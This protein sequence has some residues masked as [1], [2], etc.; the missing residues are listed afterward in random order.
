M[1]KEILVILLLLLSGCGRHRV[2]ACELKD[3]EKEIHINI[4]ATNDDI[5][6]IHIEEALYIPYK[7]LLSKESLIEIE[8][9]IDKDYKLIDNKLVFEYDV[10][11]DEKYSFNETIKKLDKE[12]F[13]CE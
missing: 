3:Q 10:L 2:V 8:K 9:Q 1:V 4:E 13:Y 11:I 12:Y 6:K 5:D 7:Y